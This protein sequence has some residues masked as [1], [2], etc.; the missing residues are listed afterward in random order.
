M[1]P[2]TLRYRIRPENQND[3]EQLLTELAAELAATPVPGLRYDVFQLNDGLEYLHFIA[4]DKTSHGPLERP[5]A[6]A[7]F[8]EQLRDRCENEPHRETL[9]PIIPAPQHQ[10]PTQHPDH[11]STHQHQAPPIA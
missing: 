6:L 2:H 1:N 4:Y 11:S 9:Q 3:H 10:A 7:D 8:H 5:R